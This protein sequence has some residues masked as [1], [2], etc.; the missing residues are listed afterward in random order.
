[1]ETKEVI[2]VAPE[3]KI[4]KEEVKLSPL[5]ASAPPILEKIAAI[6]NQGIIK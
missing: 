1:M 4:I 5:Q 2:A 3:Q 6:P